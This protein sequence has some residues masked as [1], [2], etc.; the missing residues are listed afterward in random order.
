MA[1]PRRGSG[2]TPS[3]R[4]GGGR[5]TRRK[6]RRAAKLFGIS[7]SEP[8][9]VERTTRR[10]GSVDAKRFPTTELVPGGY[11]TSACSPLVYTADVFPAGYRGNVFVCDPA[12][13]LI[14]RET[15][16]PNGV[17]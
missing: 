5:P 1:P 17:L 16:E 6:R 14:H 7:P 9:R 4:G 8:W 11:F 15:L 10:K 2:S 3:S 13:N 12:N